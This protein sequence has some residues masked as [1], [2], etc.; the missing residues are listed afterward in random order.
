MASAG[1]LDLDVIIKEETIVNEETSVTN[2]V[3][4]TLR[5]TIMAIQSKYVKDT[6]LF[7]SVD[8]AYN[9]EEY[10]FAYHQLMANKEKAIVNYL[11]S[12][13]LFTTHIRQ[14]GLKRP[15]I[16]STLKK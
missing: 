14:K 2:T 5:D 13:L 7:W 8:L 10:V 12:Y 3:T 1:I 15:S 9:S 6:P 4:N 16:Q 11:H